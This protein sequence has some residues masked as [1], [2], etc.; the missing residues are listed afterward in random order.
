M[1][2]KVT[3]NTLHL[4]SLGSTAVGVKNILFGSWLLVYF[5]QILGLEPLLASYALAIALVFDAI[6]DPLVGAWSDRFKS[7]WG[8]R[9]PFVYLA[10]IPFGLS[11]YYLYSVPSDTSQANLFIKLLVASI[12]LRTMFT[13]YET[14]RAAI[15]PEL[16]TDYERRN[17]LSGYGVLYGNMGLGIMS[18]IMLAYFLVETETFSGP[19]AFLNPDAY[20]KFGLLACFLILVFGFISASSTHKYIPDMVKPESKTFNFSQFWKEIIESLSNRN[21]LVLFI[22]GVILALNIGIFSSLDTYFSIYFWQWT[23]EEI[24][25]FPIIIALPVVLAG[26]IAAPLAKGRSK[27][28]FAIGV[29]LVNLII[30]PMPIWLRLLDPYFPIQLFPENGTDSLW[31]AII[32]FLSVGYFLRTVGWIL[33]ISMVYDVVED[34][35]LSTGRRDEGLY[36]SA[37]GFIQ[38]IISGLGVVIVGLLLEIVGFD[39]KNPTVLEM[40]QPIYRLAYIQAILSPLLGLAS[41]SCMFFYNISKSSHDEALGTLNIDKD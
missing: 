33:V 4:Y 24:K 3:N 13:F 41:I 11:A 39:V 23:P 35:Q 37:N 38:K 32:L 31:W 17:T 5:N 19:Q 15:G 16:I 28:N 21:W 36:L 12:L 30:E 29:F 22:G 1:N 34:G 6:S 2:K 27:K 8:R 26:F 20:P 14:P 9:H 10:I 7:R 25:L 18:Y 40:Q